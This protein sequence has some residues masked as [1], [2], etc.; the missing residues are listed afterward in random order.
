M[1]FI[2]KMSA[3][4]TLKGL[5]FEAVTNTSNVNLNSNSRIEIKEAD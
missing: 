1:R 4:Q 2:L 5:P 3:T